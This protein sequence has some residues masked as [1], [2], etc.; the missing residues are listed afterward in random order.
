VDLPQPAVVG[1]DREAR[2]QQLLKA[3]DDAAGDVHELVEEL[4]RQDAALDPLREPGPL[5][6]REPQRDQRDRQPERRGKPRQGDR[7]DERQGQQ[8]QQQGIGA[9]TERHDYR[10]HGDLLRPGALLQEQEFLR[11]FPGRR[12]GPAGAGGRGSRD[13]LAHVPRRLP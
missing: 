2:A 3:R 7:S 12:A 8:D 9:G 10:A 6:E 4:R 11:E 1:Q 13:R 5:A